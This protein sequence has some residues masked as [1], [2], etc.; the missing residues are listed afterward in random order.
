MDGAGSDCDLADRPC[1]GEAVDEGVCLGDLDIYGDHS[2]WE[3]AVVREAEALCQ[4]HL[5]ELVVADVQPATRIEERRREQMTARNQVG[6]A[7][8]QASLRKLKHGGGR[9]VALRVGNSPR[10]RVALV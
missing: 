7:V 9:K 10:Y 6:E 1:L 3:V 4:G 8:H 2:S 5:E